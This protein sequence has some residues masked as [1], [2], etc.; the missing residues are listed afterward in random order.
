MVKLPSPDTSGYSLKL[1]Y[2]LFF[3][4]PILF[5]FFFSVKTMFFINFVG[6]SA[7]H[8]HLPLYW[9]NNWNVLTAM[10]VLWEGLTCRGS[11]ACS[12]V[13]LPSRINKHMSAG[14]RTLDPVWEVD[15]ILD[16]S[17]FRCYFLMMW[18]L[19]SCCHDFTLMFFSPFT[20]GSYL[21]VLVR[22][23]IALLHRLN[24]I[25]FYIGLWGFL[26]AKE[27]LTFVVLSSIEGGAALILLKI[28][29]I[30]FVLWFM[31]ILFFVCFLYLFQPCGLN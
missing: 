12:R 28:S 8:L 26:Y 1:F 31:L 20:K 13:L 5:L 4:F 19:H 9:G 2:C 7:W 14:G 15:G 6:F 10:Y 22:T 24:H 18:F 25:P 29:D 17:A 11:S 30:S 3:F 27:N 21:P 16:D 23:S